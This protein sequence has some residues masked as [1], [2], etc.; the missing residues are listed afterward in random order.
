MSTIKLNSGHECPTFGL[1]TYKLED[2]EVIKHAVCNLG[3]RML[4]CASFYKNEEMVG[5]AIK[6]IFEAGDIKR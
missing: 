3:Y 4:D 1:G 2:P 5:T 6:S